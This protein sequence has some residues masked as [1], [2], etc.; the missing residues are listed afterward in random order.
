[1]V[2]PDT[3]TIQ[4]D[5]KF[6]ENPKKVL[7]NIKTKDVITKDHVFFP[8]I[9]S[10]RLNTILGRLIDLSIIPKF[11]QS[12]KLIH[13]DK[14]FTSHVLRKTKAY[15]EY[16]KRINNAQNEVREILGQTKGTKSIFSYIN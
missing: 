16:R 14:K 1:M 5:K 10:N 11:I 12:L 2:L 15:N 9:K 6:S 7:D 13:P 8:R 4:N 3:K